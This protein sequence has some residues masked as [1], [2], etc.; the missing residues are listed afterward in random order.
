MLVLFTLGLGMLI[1]ARV[2][3]VWEE[4]N[5]PAESRTLSAQVQELGAEIARMEE[6]RR[7]RR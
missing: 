2:A 6:G 1:G 5:T 7:E 3:G 4:F